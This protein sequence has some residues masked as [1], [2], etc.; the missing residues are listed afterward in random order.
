M[1][2]FWCYYGRIWRYFQ[3][4][5]VGSVF[6]ERSLGLWLGLWM[7]AWLGVWLGLWL[8]IQ[9]AVG[10]FVGKPTVEAVEPL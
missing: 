7:G 10:T 1:G 9:V 2:F 4:F 8:G 6:W 3:T 5:V